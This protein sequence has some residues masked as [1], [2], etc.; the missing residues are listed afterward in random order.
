MGT[1]LVVT[2]EH[3]HLV[4]R[5]DDDAL[6]RAAAVDEVARDVDRLVSSLVPCSHISDG[7][8]A[9]RI[10]IDDEG[11]PMKLRATIE[12]SSCDA[13]V[14]PKAARRYR[15]GPRWTAATIP[16]GLRK[17][18]ELKAGVWGELVVLAGRVRLRYDDPIGREVEL[19]AGEVATVPPEVRHELEML[20]N[21]V[22]RL[23]FY[24]CP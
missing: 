8:R 20:D 5:I 15:E 12:G 17:P 1:V 4:P 13:L 23:D 10:R 16:A 9:R 11:H 19:G 3:F 18:H 21:A 2:G 7:P 6:E 24:R 22:V 14:R